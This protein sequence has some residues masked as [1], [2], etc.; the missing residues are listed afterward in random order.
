M[1]HIRNIILFLVPFLISTFAVII[2]FKL[3]NKISTIS[4]PTVPSIS[5]SDIIKFSRFSLAKAPSQTFLGNI[6]MMDGEV[7][8]EDRNATEA[9]RI[10]SAVNVQQGESIYTGVDGQTTLNFKDAVEVNI[11]KDS[12]VNVIQTLP[13]DLVFKQTLGSV[14]YKKLGTYPVSIRVGHLLIECQG[15]TKVSFTKESPITTVVVVN[16]AATIAYNNLNNNSRVVNLTTGQTLE[17]NEGN[18]KSN[19][20]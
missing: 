19:L 12:G 9:A 17:F 7:K 8:Y 5:F 10:Y 16:G 11:E 4:L 6:T 15:E 18:R 13:L 2:Y 3:T 20:K 1:K 14:T